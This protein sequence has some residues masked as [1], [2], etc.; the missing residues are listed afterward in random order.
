MKERCD[1]E[2]D[3]MK[4]PKTSHLNDVTGSTAHEDIKPGSFTNQP[5]AKDFGKATSLPGLYSSLPQHI[6]LPSPHLSC[7]RS[8]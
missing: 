3:E 4:H 6:S 1:G 5:A 7:D 2:Y 8:L